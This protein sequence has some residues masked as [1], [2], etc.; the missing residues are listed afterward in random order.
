MNDNETY[1]D[2]VG[3]FCDGS[4]LATNG[5]YFLLAVVGRFIRMFFFSFHSSVFWDH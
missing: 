4:Y 1:Y 3:D 2:T 5:T